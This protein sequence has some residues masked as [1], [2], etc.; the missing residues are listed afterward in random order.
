MKSPKLYTIRKFTLKQV[1]KS[2]NSLCLSEKE[3]KMYEIKQS[4]NMLFRQVRIITNYNK[5]Y[6]PYIV[7]LDC[8]GWKSVQEELKDILRNGFYINSTL[9]LPTEKS[10]SMSRNAVIGFVDASIEKELDKR[11]TMDMEIENTVL[12]KLLAYRGLFFSGCFCLEN[13]HPT[14]VIVDDYAKVIPNQYIKYLVDIKKPY[15][16]KDGKELIW[17]EKGIEEGYRDVKINLWD[18]SGIHSPQV[19]KYIKLQIE[20]DETP[21]SILWRLPYGKGMTHEID[22]VQWFK[23]H[24]ISTIKDIYEK[25]YNIEDVDIIV[26]KSFYKGF[27]YFQKYNDYRDWGL[28]WEKFKQYNHCIGVATWNYSFEDEPQM[29]KSSYQILQDL[30]LD[31][32]KFIELADYTKKWIDNIINGDLIYTYCFLG[33]FADHA[34]PSNDYMNTIL[35]NPEMLKEECVRKYLLDLLKKNIDLMKCGKL[36]LEGAFKFVVSDLVM[37]LEYISGMEVKG[38]LKSN[39]FFS[40]NKDGICLEE[41]IIERNPHISKQEHLILQGA[42]HSLLEKYCKH[43]SNVCQ[44]NGYSISLSRLNG[45]DEDKLIS[46]LLCRN[47]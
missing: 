6:N 1:I 45:A 22:F 2:N 15:T 39:E 27:K 32:N 4:D 28:Y 30:E 20:S 5:E 17:Y 25:E 34:K 11:M 3:Q 12:A 13:W 14:I 35:K 26:S 41:R 8:R 44:I 23:E 24:G 29:T 33:L 43:L 7:F 42:T 21:T 10:A 46:V 9:F 40:V 47:A 31:F 16:N 36:Y 37:F 38:T 19:T 18:G